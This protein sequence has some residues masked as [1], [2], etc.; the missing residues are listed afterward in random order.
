MAL[1]PVPCHCLNQGKVEAVRLAI[2]LGL[3]V[4]RILRFIR[5]EMS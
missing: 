1:S 5:G 4:P 2:A 3:S